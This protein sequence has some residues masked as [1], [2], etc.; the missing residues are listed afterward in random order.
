M[1]RIWSVEIMKKLNVDYIA[2]AGK[3]AKGK[4]PWFLDNPEVEK[5][6]SITMAVAGE[7]AVARERLDTLERILESK[8]I[9][10]REEIESYVPSDNDA[11]ERQTWHAEYLARIMRIIQQEREALETAPDM[12]EA[13]EDLAKEFTTE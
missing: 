2:E 3:K 13:V 11:H 10:S 6:L 5:V 4:R 8:G 12:N 1:D 7:L 9:M